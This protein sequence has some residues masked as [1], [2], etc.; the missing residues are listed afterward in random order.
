VQ[1]HTNRAPSLQLPTQHFADIFVE[2][3]FA[4]VNDIL[5][6]LSYHEFMGWYRHSYP[7]KPLDSAK[8]AILYTVFAF[9]SRDDINGP[10][11]IYFSYALGA[12]G[13][14]LGQPGLET[15]QALTLMV[16]RANA[17]CSF[18]EFVFYASNRWCRSVDL[19]GGCYSSCSE[20]EFIAGQRIPKYP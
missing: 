8:Q 16:C 3:Y 17:S 15:I 4:D 20:Y 13:P 5:C 1:T 9:G 11:D 6:V 19:C 14:V 7:E 2:R 10:A 18:S 12:I